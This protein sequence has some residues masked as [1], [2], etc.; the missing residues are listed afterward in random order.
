MTSTVLARLNLTSPFS[1]G[2]INLGD[3]L[4]SVDGAEVCGRSLPEVQ[5]LLA[6]SPGLVQLSLRR[7][8]QPSPAEEEETALWGR[9]VTP[10]PSK[11]NLIDIKKVISSMA[12][13][14]RTKE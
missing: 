9:S 2:A 3:Q 13:S 4:V 5:T 10:S 7:E 14:T 12:I 6:S 11:L 8:R 1:I